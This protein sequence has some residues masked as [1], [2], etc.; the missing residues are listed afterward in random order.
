MSRM[1]ARWGWLALGLVSL[2]GCDRAGDHDRTSTGDGDLGAARD[3]G[4]AAPANRPPAPPTGARV[5]FLGT[6]LT[7]GLDLDPDQAYPALIQRKLD[8][9]GLA[10]TAVNAGVSG[11]TSAG[12]LRRMDWLLREPVKVLVIETGAND[13]LRGLDPD[14]LE[15]NIQA[16]IDRAR[17]QAPPPEVV[18]LGMQALPNY[19]QAYARRFNA[20]YPALA[21]RNDV[22]LVPFLLQGVAGVDSLNQADLMH[23]TAAGQ[24]RVAATVWPELE[25]VLRTGSG[26]GSR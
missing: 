11:E 12:A 4:A 23:P 7:A 21:R 22:P 5:V 14:S 19:G 24:R 17:R 6:S 18:L 15:A 8:S 26:R 16:M 2:A 25:R 10:L 3:V 1:I 9:A 20:V 13:M